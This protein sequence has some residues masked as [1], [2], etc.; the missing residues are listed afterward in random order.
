MWSHTSLNGHRFEYT[1]KGSEI[2]RGYL[3]VIGFYIVGY[4]IN[5]VFQQIHAG[6][7]AF[8]MAI[9]TILILILTPYLIFGAHRYKAT[10]TRYRGIALSVNSANQTEFAGRFYGDTIKSILTSGLYSPVFY[11]NI[12]RGLVQAT[13][14]GNL[15]FDQTGDARQEWVISMT[16]LLFIIM[17]FGLFTPWAILRKL[18]YRLE[19]IRID[20]ARF[21]ISMNG[22]AFGGVML[23]SIVGTVLTFGLAAPWISTVVY[24]YVL[25]NTKM[26]GTID[27]SKVEQARLDHGAATSEAGSEFMDVELGVF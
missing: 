9:F 18:R 8:Y 22:L 27:F 3:K 12:H 4:L 16:N 14:Y 13:S 24:S 17:T 15:K 21:A 11:F 6:L 5:G 2:F 10:R 7:S 26:L 23:M 25:K 19:H 1:G 20:S